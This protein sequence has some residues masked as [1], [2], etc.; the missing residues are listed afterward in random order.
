MSNPFDYI[1]SINE[2]KKNMMRGTD[3]DEL[4]EKGYKPFL[5]NRALSY[6]VDTIMQ[7][8]I[9]N[10]ISHTDSLLQYEYLLNSVRKR[11]RYAKWNKNKDD[12]NLEVVMEYY[13]CGINKANDALKI[14]SEKDLSM[15]KEQLEKGGMNG[16]KN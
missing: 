3:N 15:I 6:H 7:A 4:A 12:A 9:A 13:N 2:T 1:K 14:L 5:S 16:H 8:N 11:K 10:G